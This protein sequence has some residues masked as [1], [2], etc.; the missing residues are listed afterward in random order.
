MRGTEIT[1]NAGTQQ[2]CTQRYFFD[3]GIFLQFIEG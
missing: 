2:N 1:Q 3:W